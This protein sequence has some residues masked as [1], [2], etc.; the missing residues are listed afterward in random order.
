[1]AVAHL[2]HNG[3]ALNVEPLFISLTHTESFAWV[4]TIQ[5][6]RPEERS[7]ADIRAEESHVSCLGCEMRQEDAGA[8]RA[9]RNAVYLGTEGNMAHHQTTDW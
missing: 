4:R 5:D 2:W 1:M 3:A 8:P 7:L 6:D 9:W